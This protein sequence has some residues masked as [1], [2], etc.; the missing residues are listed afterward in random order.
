MD[1]A[2]RKDLRQA[3]AWPILQRIKLWLDA[4][5][6]SGTVLPRSPIGQAIT[7]ARNQWPALQVYLS[8]GNLSIDNNAAERALRRVAIGRK[9][10]L[11]AGTDDSAM[12]HAVL[13]T[14][15]ASAQR[16]ELDPQFYLRS[17]LAW[18]PATPA[19]QI[20]RFL[21]DIW[22]RDWMTEHAAQLQAHHTRIL[23]GSN[24][25]QPR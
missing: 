6:S 10:W 9:N 7:Y 14:L 15:I 19:S 20:E 11:W 25:I 17:V 2:Q 3:R 18:L 16:H 21:P 12:G 1:S 13:W 4:E 22:K 8:H 23:S 5:G 24:I